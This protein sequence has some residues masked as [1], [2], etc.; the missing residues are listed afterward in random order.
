M[1]KTQ[2]TRLLD[3]I[4]EQH[5]NYHPILS[6]AE[7]ATDLE[8]DIRVRLDANKTILPYVEAQLKSL[9]ISTNDDAEFGILR[10]IVDNQ[11]SKSINADKLT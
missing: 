3:M 9:E 5:P 2:Q 8:N 6:L 11:E 1:N 10:L 4:Q 7:I